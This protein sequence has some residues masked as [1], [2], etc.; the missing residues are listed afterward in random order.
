MI[1]F[2][3]VLFLL[4][5]GFHSNALYAQSS[6]EKAVLQVVEVLFEGMKQGDSALVSDLFHPDVRMLTSYTSSDG[7][8][9]LKEGSLADF[10]KAIG[11]PHPE[12]W[13]EKIWNTEIRVDDNLAQIWTDYAFYVDDRFSHCGVDAFQLVKETD[14]KWRIVHLIDTRR[15]EPCSKG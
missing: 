2:A 14:G 6:E 8:P 3:I 7:E 11:T 15:K 12:V 10:L 13:N 5:I 4:S 1:R 9:V